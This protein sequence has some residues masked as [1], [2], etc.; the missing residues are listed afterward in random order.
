M[1]FSLVIC[2]Y[3]RPQAL[4]TLLDSVKAQSEYPSQ[5]VI[6]DGSVDDETQQSLG[7]N[8]YPNLEYYKVDKKDRGLTRQRNYGVQKIANEIDIVCFLDDD[9]VLT[10]NYFEVLL[11]TYNHHPEALGVG[12]YIIN[13]T[14]WEPIDRG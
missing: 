14:E 1:G 4:I 5:I 11:S 3:M 8:P 2:T 7:E 10:P 6:V 9:I 12:G 13:E